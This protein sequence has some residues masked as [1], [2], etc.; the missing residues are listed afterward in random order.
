M[1]IES[2]FF[3]HSKSKAFFST[4]FCLV[5]LWL[6]SLLLFRFHLFRIRIF[7]EKP[8]RMSGDL[9]LIKK[10]ESLLQQAVSVSISAEQL[11]RSTRSSDES[12]QAWDLLREQLLEV[13]QL[14]RLNKPLY[15]LLG[16]LFSDRPSLI[17]DELRKQL[18]RIES[19]TEVLRS[20][21]SYHND[22]YYDKQSPRLSDRAFDALLSALEEIEKRLPHLQMSDSPTRRV[23]GSTTRHFPSVEHKFPMRSL[24]NTYSMKELRKFDARI[25]KQLAP[26][27][28]SYFCEQKL[29]GLAISLIYEQAKLTK[30]I[31]RGD[32][33]RGD[34][35]TDN[36]ATIP[37]LPHQLPASSPPY[38]EVRGEVLITKSHF[39]ALNA[40]RAS[41]GKA[42]FANARNTASGTIKLLDPREVAARK[43]SVFCYGLQYEEASPTQSE[44]IAQLMD[45]GFP[46]LG[47]HSCCATIQEVERYV[48]YWEK[49]R[50]DLG[51]ETDGVVVKVNERAHQQILG[52]TSKSPR[53]AIAY[54]YASISKSTELLGVRFQ[55]GR[56]GAITPVAELS[57]VLLQGSTLRRASLHNQDEIERLNLHIGDQVY[58]EKG[59]DIIP[60]VLGVKLSDRPKEA[61]AVRF[62]E[63][64][65]SC[66]SKLQRD[67]SA[68]DSYCAASKTCEPQLIARV[69]HFISRKALDITSLGKE[70][71]R[72]LIQAD[73]IKDAG[74]LYN[75]RSDQ[76]QG[77]SLTVRSADLSEI[78]ESR[79][80]EDEPLV[81]KSR[82]FQE[83]SVENI[84]KGIKASLSV[85][86]ERVLYGLGIRHIGEST[87]Y[88]L[89][90][91]FLDIDSIGRASVDELL[92]VPEIG[93]KVAHSVRDYFKDPDHL[94][95]I[96]ILGA[97]RLQLAVRSKATRQPL[98][99]KRIVISG[100]FKSYSREA[101][102]ARIQGLG[103]KILSSPSPRTDYF[104]A[105]ENIGP[106][107]QKKAEQLQIPIL[108]EEAFEELIQSS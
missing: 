60:K 46:I 56:T 25:Q 31:T 6:R 75:L 14:A 91:H 38:V 7:V 48:D 89:A 20:S 8:I 68:A 77:L 87:A 78:S 35:V 108:S 76:L 94:R 36:I 26:Q 98:Q 63:Y 84:L 72:G 2:H 101:L 30:A 41:E 37:E 19:I 55:V 50:H 105:G 18:T 62:P 103:A 83:K 34:L 9:Q 58:V 49:S 70:N 27:Q 59:G 69:L 65:P 82:S 54:K 102:R 64:C 80:T 86:F 33:Q 4:L 90:Y 44:C 21:I 43:L 71:I 24:S 95:L 74:D 92:E 47:H 3:H 106:S 66:G 96:E 29:D 11:K 10:V 88:Q 39:S 23:A 32:G 53:W 40:Q 52:H 13:E 22:L 107:K 57:P 15:H 16:Q 73:L 67:P 17:L 28:A 12:S 93:E 61:V 97:A 104:I 81:V 79:A 99:G 85:P 1:R 100:S 5:E 42:L 51:V 45:W